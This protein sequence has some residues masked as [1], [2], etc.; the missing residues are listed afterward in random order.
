VLERTTRIARICERHGVPIGAAALQFV[1]AN[2]A[3]RTV[4]IGPR[5]VAELDANLAAIEIAI[6]AAMWSDLVDAGIIAHDCATPH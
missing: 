6:P 5:S 1:L 2:P 3:I 4:L